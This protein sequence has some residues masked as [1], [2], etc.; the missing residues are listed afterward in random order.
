MREL[1]PDQVAVEFLEHFFEQ[2]TKNK[3]LFTSVHIAR[4]RLEH[5]NDR[6]PNATWLPTLC[7]RES[8]LHTRFTWNEL[9]NSIIKLPPRMLKLL[10]GLLIWGVVIVSLSLIP[11]SCPEKEISSFQFRQQIWKILFPKKCLA[12]LSE[13]PTQI[14]WRYG[15]STTWARIRKEVDERIQKTQPKLKLDYKEHPT[16]PPGSGTGIKMLLNGQLDFAQSSRRI[17]DKEIYQARQ[18][19]F[20]FREIPVAINAIAVAVHPNLK[21]RGLTISQLKAIYTGKITNWSEVGGPNLSITPYSRKK[22]A[23]G[24]VNYFVEAI[25]DGEE[26]GKN[27]QFTYNTTEAIR[28]VA[29]D[30]GGIYYASVVDIVPQCTIKPL[31]LV[32]NNDRFIAPYQEPFVHQNQCNERNRNQ[33]NSVAFKDGTY[34]ITSQLFV[35]IKKN[36]KAEEKAGYAYVDLLR[37]DEGKKLL[38]KAGFLPID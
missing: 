7:I 26:F 35:I 23:G 21:V 38:E 15:G 1:V 33:V 29:N 27:V 13:L 34:P 36:G 24:T 3:S 19:G 31:P 14:E 30:P 22:E 4:K 25:L 6:F 2:F 16:E 10:A 37:T 28:K 12:Y 17:T 8:A 20:T 18:K 11:Q 5:F 9:V 32:K